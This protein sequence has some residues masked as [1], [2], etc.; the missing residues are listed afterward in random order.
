V[1]VTSIPPAH[2]CRSFFGIHVQQDL[3]QDSSFKFNAPVIPVSSSIVNKASRI[4]EYQYFLKCHDKTVISTKRFHEHEPNHQHTYRFLVYQNQIQCPNFLMYHIQMSLKH[5]CFSVFHP[6]RCRFTDNYIANF[7]FKVSNP[8][9]SKVF[10]N[11]IT[12]LLLEGRG[13]AFKSNIPKRFWFQIS[14]LTHLLIFEVL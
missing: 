10:I 2:L 11:A 8:R 14:F 3:L 5:N 9:L 13:T 4:A 6:S 7:I 12:D 1:A